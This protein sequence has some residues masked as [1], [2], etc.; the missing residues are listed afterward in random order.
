MKSILR[1]IKIFFTK[2]KKKEEDVQGI[3]ATKYGMI[4]NFIYSIRLSW[5]Y[6]RL[7]IISMIACSITAAVY[8]LISVYIPKIVLELVARKASAQMMIQVLLCVGIFMFLVGYARQRFR[9]VGEYGF[10]KIQYKLMGNYLNKVFHTDFKNMEN[11]DF[12][13]L[14]ERARRATY[15]GQG[16]H[17]Y[18]MRMTDTLQ[19]FLSAVLAGIPVLLIHPLLALALCVVSYIRYRI[20]NGTMQKE[21]VA[22]TDAMAGN[23]R[24]H[25]YL[26]QSTRDFS[27][28]KDIRLFGM[29]K[30]IR[31]LWDDL[32]AVFFKASRRTHNQWTLSEVR[33]ST[34]RFVQNGLLYG[35]LVFMVLKRGMSIPDFVLYIGLVRTFSESTADLFSTL[36]FTNM[37][38]LQMDDFRTFMDWIEE[39]PDLEKEEGTIT[40]I[41]LKQYEF[42]F[43]NVSFRYPGHEKY[44]LK[45]LNIKI[46]A[47][48]KLA[49][50]GVNGAGKTT[51]T[52]LL[53]RLYEPTEGRILLN[54]IDIKKYDRSAYYQLF[55][56]VFQNVEVFACPVWE[57]V[58]LKERERTDMDFVMKSLENSGMEEKIQTYKEGVETQLLRI[59]DAQG[60]DLSGGERQRL[61]M[62][63]ALYRRRNVI[64]LDEPTAA[65]DALAEDRMYQE[66]NK[67]V[68]GKTSIFISHRLS[69]TRFCDRIILFEDGQV[70]EEGT[71]EQLMEQAGKY[72]RMYQVQAQYYRKGGA[73]DV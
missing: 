9:I 58:S 47:G 1:K 72:A 61:A 22:F 32:N 71:H 59:F 19:S 25:N 46:D 2:K 62:A 60:I 7:F 11:P 4:N 29:E 23:W 13:D 31:H 69:S 64:V 16:F 52:K 39:E 12:L 5:K 51:L 67:M 53:M 49:V 30:W 15:Y 65:L 68:E 34:M 17:G 55:S 24:K 20:F 43:E 18:C 57:N 33:M 14:T 48:M 37:N 35:I 44:V 36:I 10:D 54:G 63:R 70:A 41:D 26:A 3:K 40:D 8:P 21:K 38:K 45:N 6:C 27:Y 73:A 56:P 50:V 42:T 28:A 66:F